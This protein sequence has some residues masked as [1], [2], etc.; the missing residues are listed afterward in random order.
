MDIL[1]VVGGPLATN[2][3]IYSNDNHQCLLIDPTGDQIALVH[4]LNQNGLKPIGIL[5]THGHFDHIS[6][7]E[8]FKNH[9]QIPVYT[10]GQESIMMI[11]GETNLSA[12]FMNESYAAEATNIVIDNE[13][14]EISDF[15]F[16]CITVVGHTDESV[17]YYDGINKV[18]FSGDVLF[19]GSIGTVNFTG[20]DI[21]TFSSNIV[22]KLGHLPEN[23]IV[24]PGHGLR[25]TIGDE[26]ADNPYL[27]KSTFP[28]H[29]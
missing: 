24:C 6:C 8:Y 5:V 2:T 10:S 11:N 12:H 25:T 14:I 15:K 4:K 18:L 21:E 3:Y 19:K 9:Y 7:V 29:G 22:D 16:Q 27:V 20:Y 1:R 13:I 26:L 23:T 17:C 28:K